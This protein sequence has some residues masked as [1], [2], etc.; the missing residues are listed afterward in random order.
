MRKITGLG[1]RV[2]L[3]HAN[4]AIKDATYTTV[5]RRTGLLKAGIRIK[6]VRG[7]P[8]ETLA[9]GVFAA[10]ATAGFARR[11]TNLKGARKMRGKK[12]Q[13][14]VLLTPYYWR[15][16]EFGTSKMKARTYIRPVFEAVAPKMIEA[17]VA[18]T[19]EGI[20]TEAARLPK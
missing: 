14:K 5:R 16:I 4:R 13:G 20:E 10:K 1:L 18:R 15:F 6:G 9:M 8:K 3:G 7:E 11:L 19:R 12:S 17:F 2:A